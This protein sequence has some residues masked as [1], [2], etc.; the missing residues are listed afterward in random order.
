[1]QFS[2]QSSE[3]LKSTSHRINNI[4][5]ATSEPAIAKYSVNYIFQSK[6]HSL[7]SL[8][9]GYDNAAYEK[10][11]VPL[12]R[13]MRVLVK[14]VF[15]WLYRLH[16]IFS[17]K[18]LTKHLFKC[19]VEI[20]TTSWG[21]D[22]DVEEKQVL[23]VP[24]PL[25]WK[26]HMNFI[27]SLHSQKILYRF[28]GYPYSLIKLVKFLLIR[29]VK[30]LAEL[31]IGAARGAAEDIMK[32]ATRH[33]YVMDDVEAASFE[34][35]NLLESQDLIVNF[36]AHGIGRYS[37]FYS[38][39]N[40]TF[41]NESQAN[42]YKTFNSFQTV[43]V[44]HPTRRV[45][46][47]KLLLKR[48]CFVSQL[49]VTQSEEYAKIELSCVEKLKALSRAKGVPFYIKSHPNQVKLHYT[50][51]DEIEFDAVKEDRGTLFFTIYST[52]YYDFEK[53]GR[54]YLIMTRG[55]DSRAL[56][57]DDERLVGFENENNNLSID[58]VEKVF[59]ESF[60]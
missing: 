14:V 41:F 31:E 53:Y 22:F 20:N 56:F 15:H 5:K 44:E 55:I 60:L 33:Y 12:K 26:R 10:E 37:I 24:F 59:S 9:I 17:R 32:V 7:S 36:K 29:N 18:I 21:Q 50:D 39:R 35:N 13:A 51:V 6:P 3:F 1:M 40:A 42:F 8:E 28:Y 43:T 38:A 57:G 45:Q 46:T 11:A 52:A 49:S 30:L 23:I 47:D 19:W 4:I 2:H 54:T 58:T 16:F 27:K 25:G 48:V 34:T